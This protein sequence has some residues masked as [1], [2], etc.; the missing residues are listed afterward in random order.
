MQHV[1]MHALLPHALFVV[2]HAFSLAKLPGDA[3]QS[4]LKAPSNRRGRTQSQPCR[5]GGWHSKMKVVAKIKK[6][7]VPGPPA[8]SQ[9]DHLGGPPK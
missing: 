4:R 2:S 1:G 7:E 6:F 8:C 9:G 3:S 5:A